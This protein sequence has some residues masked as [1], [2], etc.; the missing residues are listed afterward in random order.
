MKEKNSHIRGRSR[1][2]SERVVHPGGDGE[3][4]DSIGIAVRRTGAIR[5]PGGLYARIGKEG[6]IH[7]LRLIASSLLPLEGIDYFPCVFTMKLMVDSVT[8]KISIRRS[9]NE[10]SRELAMSKVR[11]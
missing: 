1:E 4:A 10:I 5:F 6:N 3:A 8:Y 2:S 9:W 11:S 7:P